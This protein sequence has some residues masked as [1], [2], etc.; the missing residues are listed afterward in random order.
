MTTP[1]PADRDHM[2]AAACRK[3]WSAVVLTVLNDSWH[4]VAKR[5]DDK[6]KLRAE[7]LRYFRSRDGREVMALAGI[8]ADPER[9]ADAAVDLSAR[10][11][12]KSAF[13]LED[14]A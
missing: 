6:D 4:A 3:L 2:Q 13:R 11:R 1:S 12:T 14:Q 9:M 5:P 10:D 8:T 7:A